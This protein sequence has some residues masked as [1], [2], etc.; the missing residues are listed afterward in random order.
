MPGDKLHVKIFFKNKA[1]FTGWC[2]FF[3]SLILYYLIANFQESASEYRTI[4][5]SFFPYTLT[6][7]LTVLGLLLIREGWRTL[8][9]PVLSINFRS[10]DTYRTIAL[11]LIL[12]IF[13]MVLTRIGFIIDSLLF[14]ISV[15]VL[16]GERK[17]VR[18]IGMALV[19]SFGL[20]FLFA[21]LFYVSL[22]VG[23]WL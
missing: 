12:G 4:S 18:V 15:Q 23:S 1:L 2:I 17:I 8:P 16:L 3:F 10:R 20:Y 6:V 5:P 21:K 9:G 19:I 7:M 11:L 14:M 13:S 22:P